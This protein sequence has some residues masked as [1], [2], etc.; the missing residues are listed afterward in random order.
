MKDDVSSLLD[1]DLDESA[2]QRAVD[3]I[4]RDDSA[5]KQWEVYCLIGDSLRGDLQSRPGFADDVMARIHSEPTVL[6]PRREAE[7]PARKSANSPR[8]LFALAASVVAF[9]VVGW[10]VASLIGG[11]G[12]EPMIIADE[13]NGA[14]LAVDSTEQNRNYVFVHQAMNGGGT[15][16]SAIHF[17][18]T[19]ATDGGANR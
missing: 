4:R 14:I 5:R 13:P 18:R 3:A 17:V 9:G 15:V 16:P 8:R 2:A 19:V 10:S 1:G 7:N 12:V 11:S 6:A